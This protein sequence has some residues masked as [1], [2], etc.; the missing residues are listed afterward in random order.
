MNDEDTDAGEMRAEVMYGYYL[1][2][3]NSKENTFNKYITGK[4]IN[5]QNMSYLKYKN[6]KQSVTQPRDNTT[7]YYIDIPNSTG[8][9]KGFKRINFIYNNSTK[10]WSY[11]S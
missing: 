7:R 3:L 11:T 10:Y 2:Y 9:T 8:I 6:L 5:G 1:L 4:I